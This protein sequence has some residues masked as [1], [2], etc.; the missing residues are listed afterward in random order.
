MAVDG[1]DDLFVAMGGSFHNVT[2]IY[3]GGQRR[4]VA[5]SGS[6]VDANNVAATT[7][8][9]YDPSG[10]AL[11]PNGIAVADAGTHY[12]YLIDNSGIIHI[13]AGN[14]TTTTTSPG[15]ATGTGLLM[16]D[17]LAIDAAGDIYIA[18][19]T[20]NI[21]YAV[22]SVI[23]NGTNIWPVI[24]T[25]AAGYTGDT[26]PS[27]AA[28][29]D[30]PLAIALDGSSD[31]FVVD[32]GNNALREVSY[33]RTST[34]GFGNVLIGTTSSP[35]LQ[36][37]A[38]AGN[39]SL[40]FTSYPFTTTD[41]SHY[42]VSARLHHMCRNSVVS[43]GV[44]DIGYTF[45]PT[46]IG[47]APAGQSNLPSN[48]YNSQQTVL[49]STSGSGGYCTVPLPFT[50]LSETE[51]YG[52]SFS[53]SFTFTGSLPRQRHH[54]LLHW[55]PDALHGPDN[56]RIGGNHHM[57][58]GGVAASPS[59]ATPSASPSPPPIRSTAR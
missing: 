4:V 23:S 47:P 22:Y 24:G 39:T 53:E 33:P 3:A 12:V 18:D 32:S 48:S 54:G 35:Q 57:Q 27:T 41:T 40:T 25:G 31:L 49:F 17:G 59:A 58:R 10:I 8:V 9:F 55:R 7:A 11:G 50:L 15:V 1:F 14:G 21:V 46:A 42:T 19:D 36:Y 29:L 52:Y 37:L 13:V 16:P 43:G 34:I 30:A 28:T 26:G 44:C 45:T 38:N 5:G 6:V 20:A 51:V 56:Q 2:E